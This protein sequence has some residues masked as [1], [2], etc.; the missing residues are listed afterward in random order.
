[1]LAERDRRELERE[2]ARAQHAALH[3]VRELTQMRVAVRE[4]RPRVADAD[5]RTAVEH[6][7]AEAFGLDP[8]AVHESVEVVAAEPVAAPKRLCCH[9]LPLER[10]IV[11]SQEVACDS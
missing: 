3:G 2:A 5:H 11:R 9:G 6:V 7:L 8:R 1:D 10:I 4:L